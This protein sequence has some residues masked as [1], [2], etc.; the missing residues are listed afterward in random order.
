MN[1]TPFA[2]VCALVSLAVPLAAQDHQATRRV[3]VGIT[4]P[5]IGVL[6]PINVAPHLR[7]EPF[8]DFFAARADFPVTSDTAWQSS[9][10]IGLGLFSVA[11]PQERLAVY[12]G[13]RIGYLHGSTKVNGSV[14]QTSTTSKGW[15]LA[16]A[17]GA[18]YSMVARFSM[19]AE[20]KVQFNHTSS[21]SNGSLD[22]GPSLFARSW[23][24]SG[25]LVVRFFL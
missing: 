6:L 24:S 1:S 22:I 25:A 10:Q 16:G 14:G 8:V 2:M 3:G 23:F 11:A 17:I 21:T 18:E 12:F 15:F 13:P 4:V 5:D 19:G 9:T 7:L 20:A